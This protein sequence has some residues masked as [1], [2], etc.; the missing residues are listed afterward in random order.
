MGFFLFVKIGSLL[1][2][3]IL[4]ITTIKTADCWVFKMATGCLKWLPAVL[5]DGFLTIQ[6]PK[7]AAV[8]RIF[9]GQWA[10]IP[11]EC[12]EWVSMHFSWVFYFVLWCFCLT[13]IFL[14]RII[15]VKRGTTVF[16]KAFMAGIWWLLWVF[17][18]LWSCS[19][20]CFAW[21]F[22]SLCGQHL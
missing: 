9:A 21:H 18:A 8:W 16:S 4:C 20:G 3:P 22:A 15:M 6:A 19:E 12:I 17:W 7:M 2:E 11:L 1:W 10:F 5:T 13:A 14:E